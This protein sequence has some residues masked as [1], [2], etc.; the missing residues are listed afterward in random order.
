MMLMITVGEY[1][2]FKTIREDWNLYL[3]EENVLLKM[4]LVLIKVLL[5]DIGEAGNPGY[6]TNYQIILGIIPPK[7]FLG[8]PSD[9]KYTSA[10]ILDSIVKDDVKVE[11]TIQE[12][13]NEYELE[14]GARLSIKIILTKA[15]KTKLF[16]EMGEPIFHIQ[17]Q[18]IMKGNIPTE[19]RHRYQ[20][21]YEQL[22]EK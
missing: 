10:E 6:M 12:D 13:W 19:L 1:I 9:R 22:R 14:D 16:D 2:N 5:R 21:L 17:H 3:L 18:A 4:K 11:K 7:E 15:S 20:K 8:K